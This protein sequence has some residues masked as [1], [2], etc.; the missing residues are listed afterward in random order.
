M[1]CTGVGRRAQAFSCLL[2]QRPCFVLEPGLIA[3]ATSL[4]PSEHTSTTLRA[5]RCHYP[6]T[7]SPSVVCTVRISTSPSLRSPPSAPTT[8]TTTTT[9]SACSPPRHDACWLSPK[10]HSTAPLAART[11]TTAH[12]YRIVCAHIPRSRRYCTSPPLDDIIVIII[13]IVIVAITLARSQHDAIC[14]RRFTL[15]QHTG[16]R[17][18]NPTRHTRLSIT[19]KNPPE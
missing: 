19:T 7:V 14:Q 9:A 13:I 6:C 12:P 15:R 3:P 11:H 5:R 10:P 17:A 1:A 8:T 16:H 18:R 4:T 2:T